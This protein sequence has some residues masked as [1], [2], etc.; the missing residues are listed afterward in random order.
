M[1]EEEREKKM[2]KGELGK[3]NAKKATMGVKKRRVAG[4]GIL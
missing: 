1:K 2:R 3:M 4:E